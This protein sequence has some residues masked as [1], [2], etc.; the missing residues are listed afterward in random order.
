MSEIKFVLFKSNSNSSLLL[1]PQWVHEAWLSDPWAKV[2]RIVS[3]M[4][5]FLVSWQ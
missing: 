1:A 5:T 2:V 3:D 4:R